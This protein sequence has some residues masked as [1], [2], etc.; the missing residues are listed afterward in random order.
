MLNRLLP[1]QDFTLSPMTRETSLQRG[2]HNIIEQESSV[3]EKPETNDLEPFERLP[4]QAEGDE[5]DEEG[6]TGVDC[7]AGGGGDGVGY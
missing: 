3:D 6:A 4:A 5:P 1:Q 2:L 7:A